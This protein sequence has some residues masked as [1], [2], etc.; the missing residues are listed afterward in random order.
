MRRKR[1]NIRFAFTASILVVLAVIFAVTLKYKKREA[2]FDVMEPSVEQ[3]RDVAQTTEPEPNQK[4]PEAVQGQ[5]E[6]E[7]T[8]RAVSE[9]EIEAQRASFVSDYESAPL[10]STTPIKYLTM[11]VGGAPGEV[12]FNWFSPSGAGGKAVLCDTAT[13]ETQTIAAQTAASVTEPGF[14]YNKAR[15]SGLKEYT[16]Y[17]Y[18]VGNDAGWSPE[19]SFSTK[20]FSGDFTFL[21]V[22]D[23][24]IGQAQTEGQEETADRWDK[25]VTRLTRYVPNAV[26]M[27][28]LGDQVAGYNDPGNYMGFFSHLGLYKI[29][30]A[31]VVGNHD[32]DNWESG[33][34]PWF[35]ERYYV[36][37]RS[38]YGCNWADT[39]GDYWFRYGNALFMVL[40]TDTVYGNT[41]HDDF[42]KE[43]CDAN[44]DAKWR[45]IMEHYP[46]YSSVEK[47]AG[48]SESVRGPFAYIAEHWDIDLFLN[49]HDHAYTRTAIMNGSCETL[50]EYDYETGA[51]AKNPAGALYVTCGTASGCI[52]QP[53]TT[54]NYAAVMQ[55]QPEVPTAIQVD[56]GEN[57]LKI[58]TYLVDSWQV[59]DEYTLEKD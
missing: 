35:Y 43:A 22:S 12:A 3:D 20:N 1:T 10:L 14:Y 41:S 5:P 34:G 37:N 42:V 55:G 33:G 21:V 24:Q 4:A 17:T 8:A 51:V 54:D 31:P 29:P 16:D 53:V 45:I 39:D 27:A 32:V 48:V 7:E 9:E 19:Y 30:L 2:N 59:Y 18:K 58:T 13:G 50:Q 44:P 23:A 11:E 38:T 15:V 47:Y 52:Y 57:T 46:G 6:P 56:V 26:F 49:G 40:N 36:P 28:H 25:V